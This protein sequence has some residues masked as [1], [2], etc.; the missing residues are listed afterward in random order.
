MIG[1][2]DTDVEAGRIYGV[3]TILTNDLRRAVQTI[4]ESEE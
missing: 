4:I 2:N 1:D 3:R